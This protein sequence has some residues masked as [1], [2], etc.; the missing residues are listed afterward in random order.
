MAT[1]TM[2]ERIALHH[3]I[4]AATDEKEELRLIK[5]IPM[6]AQL[7]LIAKEMYGKEALLAD[8]YNL[9]EAN[10]EFGDGWLDK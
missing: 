9:S 2:E 7:A 4:F 5:M 10:E 6:P 8:G 1:I 3:K